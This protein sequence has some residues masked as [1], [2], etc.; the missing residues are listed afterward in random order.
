MT[1]ELLKSDRAEVSISDLRGLFSL[2]DSAITPALHSTKEVRFFLI[3]QSLIGS[4]HRSSKRRL[5]K[6]P[7]SF[8]L[9]GDEV[10]NRRGQSQ[11]SGPDCNSLSSQLMAIATCAQRGCGPLWKTLTSSVYRRPQG[12]ESLPPFSIVGLNRTGPC[13]LL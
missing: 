8:C 11:T 3:R 1:I 2:E 7:K 10:S 4:C 9:M 6:I 5:Q 12:N 13:P